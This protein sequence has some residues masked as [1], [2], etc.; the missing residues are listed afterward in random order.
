VAK[1]GRPS[2]VTRAG[3]DGLKVVI[4]VGSMRSFFDEYRIEIWSGVAVLTVSTV[5]TTGAI[6]MLG[7][8]PPAMLAE[9]WP[10]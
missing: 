8:V 7:S 5:I 4:F 3:P 1:P 10:L 9:Y 6:L 2:T